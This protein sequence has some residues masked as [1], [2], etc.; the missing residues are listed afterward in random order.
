MSLVVYAEASHESNPGHMVVGE[1]W[2]K[3]EPSYFG[4]RFDPA[5]LPEEFRPPAQW[6][7]YLLSNKTPGLIV[8]ESR[9]VRHLL[10]AAARSYREKR[11]EV[12]TRIETQI[13]PRNEWQP[14][15][16]YSFNP[17]DFHDVKTSCYNCV[18]WATGIAN[19]LI[20]GFLPSVRQ[21]RIKLVLELLRV[22]ERVSKRDG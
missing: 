18:T 5:T 2:E 12:K 6:R 1:E 22:A 10:T 19:R 9:Y 4:F 21:G 8:D 16:E 20:P 7:E 17:D 14:H 3:E 13:P 15:A 11:G